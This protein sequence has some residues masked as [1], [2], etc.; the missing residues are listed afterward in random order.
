[1]RLRAAALGA[2]LVVTAL[3][4]ADDACADDSKWYGWQTL[5]S[6]GATLAASGITAVAIK[7][8][9]AVPAVILVSGYLIPPP[10]IHA[11]HGNG[12]AA[13]A[14]LGLRVGLAGLGILTGAAIGDGMLGKFALVVVLGSVGALAAS[15]IDAAALG[16]EDRPS[17]SPAPSPQ[18]SGL[19]VVSFGGTF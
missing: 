17:P 9:T 3:A 6:D 1:M 13:A 11:A 16:Y 15:V 12:G 14:S 5:A 19:R 4:T 2:T 8:G 10:I 7:G 18:Q